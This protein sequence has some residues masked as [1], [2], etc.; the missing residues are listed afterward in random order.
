M[1]PNRNCPDCVELREFDDLANCEKCADR[2][3]D[4]VEYDDPQEV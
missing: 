3:A 2:S 4:Y 1:K